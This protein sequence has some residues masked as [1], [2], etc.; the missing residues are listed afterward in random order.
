MMGLDTLNVKE[1]VS[2]SHDFPFRSGYKKNH[3]AFKVDTGESTLQCDDFAQFW[4]SWL[5]TLQIG[6]G[7][8]PGQNVIL[9]LPQQYVY[10]MFMYPI[11]YLAI[12]NGYGASGN[13]RF[14]PSK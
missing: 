13:W 12:L 14:C 5:D 2:C 10:D 9:T 3:T 6:K 7:K 8:Q 4:I 1:C 11:K